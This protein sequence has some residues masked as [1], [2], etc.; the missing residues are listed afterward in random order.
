MPIHGCK[1]NLC[2]LPAKY[3]GVSDYDMGEIKKP[4]YFCEKHKPKKDATVQIGGMCTTQIG[5]HTDTQV[6]EPFTIYKNTTAK[7]VQQDHTV[8]LPPLYAIQHS[9]E[10]K[11]TMSGRALQQLIIATMAEQGFTVPSSANMSI[12]EALNLSI[13]WRTEK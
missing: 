1:E 8:K 9:V 13:V 6:M 10:N 3:I 4:L 5:G 7:P 11:I 2:P 12:D